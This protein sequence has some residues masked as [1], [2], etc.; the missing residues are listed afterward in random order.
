MPD[1]P[2]W[3]P[4]VMAEIAE[5]AVRASGP[6]GQHVNK[7]STA[8]ELRLDVAGSLALPGPVKARIAVFAGRRLSR[9]GILVIFA[10]GYRSQEMNRQDGRAR[11]EEILRA[12]AIRPKVRRPTRPT[13]A[14]KTRRLEG[15]V[16]RGKVKTLRGRPPGDD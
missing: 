5:S 11:I 15:K 3:L 7:T 13:L 14:S 9:D 8:L 6:G 1:D 12:A 4:L 2:A 10:Q 16:Q